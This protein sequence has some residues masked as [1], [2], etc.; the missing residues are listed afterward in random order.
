M[1]CCDDKSCGTTATPMDLGILPKKQISKDIKKQFEVLT[2][3]FDKSDLK[4]KEA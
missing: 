1:S 4:Q 3:F 2:K